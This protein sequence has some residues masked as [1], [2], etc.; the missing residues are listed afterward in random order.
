MFIPLSV[1]FLYQILY[2][3][4]SKTKKGNM[5]KTQPNL[6]PFS[7]LCHHR[8]SIPILAELHRD[9][10]AKFVTL[11]ERLK[12]S[13]D[14]LSRTLDALTQLG[15]IKRNTGYG[16]PLRPEYI[17]TAPG[18]PIG[19][20]ALEVLNHLHQLEAT[21]TGLKKWTLPILHAVH[22]RI[23]RFSSLRE[24][25]PSLSPRAL[26][27]TLQ[28]LEQLAWLTRSEGSYELSATGRNLA[29]TLEP[30]TQKIETTTDAP[31][32][33]PSSTLPA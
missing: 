22:Q 3:V 33:K 32:R 29:E 15:L 7:A 30:L 8:W 5:V 9:N 1:L 28:D 10:G 16:H 27:L 31:T 6:E 14:A 2:S 23:N 25:L 18:K 13:R 21:N 17:L 4:K 24:T 11:V 26:T 12:I 19:Q 20:A